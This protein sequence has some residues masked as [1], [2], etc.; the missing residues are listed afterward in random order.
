MFAI[1]G[2]SCWCVS[3]RAW[4]TRV[5]PSLAPPYPF[6]P[7]S[8][9]RSPPIGCAA[10]QSSP[11]SVPRSTAT[12]LPYP[13]MASYRGTA[14][15]CTSSVS[16]ETYFALIIIMKNLYW[17]KNMTG[18][19]HSFTRKYIYIYICFVV[20]AEIYLGSLVPNS[21]IGLGRVRDQ[22]SI[23]LNSTETKDVA[24]LK[25]FVCH[26]MTHI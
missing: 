2:C 20:Y 1:P 12:G 22:S 23:N 8:S 10:G 13:P 21:T 26:I 5:G 14:G 7:P 4:W 24:K 15:C 25:M 9:R 18:F 17:L 6:C 19:I 3:C 16:G 11:P